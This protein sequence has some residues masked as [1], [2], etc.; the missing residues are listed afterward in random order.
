MQTLWFC[1]LY[2]KWYSNA[3]I[4]TYLP[5]ILRQLHFFNIEFMKNFNIIQRQRIVQT[6]VIEDPNWILW[7]IKLQNCYYVEKRNVES[8]EWVKSISYLKPESN[9]VGENWNFCRLVIKFYLDGSNC[10]RKISSLASKLEI[11]IYLA[12]TIPEVKQCVIWH[13]DHNSF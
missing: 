11:E 7:I 2:E 1:T 6:Q 8:S 3:R 12:C 9:K 4:Q 5:N 10:L 13:K